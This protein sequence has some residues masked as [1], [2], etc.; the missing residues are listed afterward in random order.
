MK[1]SYLKT[2]HLTRKLCSIVMLLGLVGV[3]VYSSLAFSVVLRSR[4]LSKSTELSLALIDSR[5]NVKNDI[6]GGNR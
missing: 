4:G 3:V 6:K 2:L 5:Q 1:C